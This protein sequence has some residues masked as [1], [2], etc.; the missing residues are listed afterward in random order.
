VAAGLIL[1]GLIPSLYVS[2]RRVWL[3]ATPAEEGGVK[4]ELAGLALQG[5][6]AFVDEFKELARDVE[7]GLLGSPSP[8]VRSNL[9]Q[10]ATSREE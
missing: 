5:K 8:E 7:L 10:A 6:M 4:V 2:R 1:A 3:R 9:D